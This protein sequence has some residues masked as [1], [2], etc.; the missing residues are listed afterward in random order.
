MDESSY[1]AADFE[2]RERKVSSE[3]SRKLLK[4]PNL[5]EFVHET[6]REKLNN[7]RS[8]LNLLVRLLSQVTSEA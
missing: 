2:T 5:C 3:K 7:M 1:A 6:E 8:S 4:Y